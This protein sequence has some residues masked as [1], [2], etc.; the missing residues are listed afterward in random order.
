MAQT[1][2]NLKKAFAGESQARNKYTYFSKIAKKEGHHFIGKIFEQTAQNEMQHAKDEFK[3]LNGINSTE[4]NLE[5]AILGEGYE[6]TT[7]YPEFAKT[8]QKEGNE[9]A[10]QLFIQIGKVEGHHKLIYEK[11][12][13]LLKNGKLYNRDEPIEWKCLKCGHIHVGTDAPSS[14]PSCGHPQGYF[15]PNDIF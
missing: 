9:N 13:K 1:D 2:E 8:A 14:C 3:L 6:A 11:L 15:E 12:L 7:M 5:E 4:K 10:A